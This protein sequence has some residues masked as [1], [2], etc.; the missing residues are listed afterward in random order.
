MQNK[1]SRIQPKTRYASSTIRPVYTTAPY[2]YGLARGVK[3]PTVSK[4]ASSLKTK[5]MYAL[6]FIFVFGVFGIYIGSRHSASAIPE[7]RSGITGYCLD[8]HQNSTAPDAL[9]DTWRCNGTAA[10][11]WSVSTNGS[12]VHNGSC[13]SIDTADKNLSNAVVLSRCTGA[14]DQEWSAGIFGYENDSNGLCLNA[15]GSNTDTQLNTASCNQLTK[16]NEVWATATWQSSDQNNAPNSSCSSLTGGPR[17]A[18]FSAEQLSVWQSNTISH[19]S[20]LNNYSDG[21]AYEA[22]CADFVS[23]IYK[24]AGEPFTNGERDGW[25]EYLADNIQNM[26]FTMHDPQ[27]YTPQAGDVAYFD[28]PGGHVEIVGIGGKKP[29]YIYGNSGIIDPKTKN[30]EMAEDTIQQNAFGVSG[31]LEYYLSPNS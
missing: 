8:D 21:N 17:V 28:Y 18:C 27:G 14:A 10:Q 22:W 16:P 24:Q 11:R 29:L 12:I 23:Y 30:G 9:V 19:E 13:L 5:A 20:L 4:T 3:S 25:D 7:I 26:G 15:P 6:I 31:Q 1:H 2:C